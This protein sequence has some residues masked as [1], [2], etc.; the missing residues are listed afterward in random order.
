MIQVGLSSN[1]S[2]ILLEFTEMYDKERNLH[3]YTLVCVSF[4]LSWEIREIEI[5]IEIEITLFSKY[6]GGILLQKRKSKNG[7]KGDKELWG[8]KS[9]YTP[10][11]EQYMRSI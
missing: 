5:E 7:Y 10:Y 4:D 3:A 2:E 11:A 8:G 9:Q 1:Q 6:K